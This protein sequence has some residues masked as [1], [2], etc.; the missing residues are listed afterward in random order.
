M[1]GPIVIGRCCIC[2]RWVTREDITTKE[3]EE[4][5]EIQYFKYWPGDGFACV[6]HPGVA[7]EYDRQINIADMAL[8]KLSGDIT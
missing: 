3:G 2:K 7:E 1:Q 4:H 5:P 8:T 6:K